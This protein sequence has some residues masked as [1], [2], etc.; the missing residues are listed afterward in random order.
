[1]LTLVNFELHLKHS[2]IIIAINVS[3]VSKDVTKIKIANQKF[4]FSDYT[5][6]NIRLI[7]I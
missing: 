6:Y 5:S 7:F 3:N 4:K 1:M 2:E